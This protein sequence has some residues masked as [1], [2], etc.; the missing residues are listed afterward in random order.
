MSFSYDPTLPA[1]LDK[2]RLFIGDTNSADPLLQDEEI[3]GL[4]AMFGSVAIASVKAANAIAAKYARFADQE[5]GD[6]AVRYSQISKMY[7]DL[8]AE[9]QSGLAAIGGA[10]P[11]AGGI[12]RSD[13]LSQE[14]DTDRVQPSFT[15]DKDDN[16]QVGGSY[17][18][19]IVIP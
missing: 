9:L 18:N 15:V 14:L 1:D 19:P 10:M 5:T 6:I 7:R 17:R 3:T 8:V 16:T 12:S 11:Y 4:L 2:V 13:K